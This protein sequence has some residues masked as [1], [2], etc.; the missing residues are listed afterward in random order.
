[1]IMCPFP[2]R[3]E[4]DE[5][6]GFGIRNEEIQCKR[7]EMKARGLECPHTK[8]AR[9]CLINERRKILREDDE[10]EECATVSA[11][12]AIMSIPN[13]RAE[14]GRVEAEYNVS[15]EESCDDIEEEEECIELPYTEAEFERV[16]TVFSAEWEESYTEPELARDFYIE[17]LGTTVT[18]KACSL[19]NGETS[20]L[21]FN[22][23]YEDM[24]V[25]FDKGY[26]QV[27]GSAAI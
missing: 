10:Y 25:F 14:F 5:A 13:T 16:G 23:K 1:M 4:K 19:W 22:E 2:R 9:R 15:L 6:F 11:K 8:A 7:L 27:W 17:E 12:D 21:Y 3:T 18:A 26:T 20:G 24:K